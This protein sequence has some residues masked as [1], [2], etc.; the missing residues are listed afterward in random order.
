MLN[1]QNQGEIE[2]L[3]R[4]QDDRD[5]DGDDDEGFPAVLVPR[6]RAIEI[7]ANENV[8]SIEI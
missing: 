6:A 4:Q 3:R 1:H 5:D 7:G 2:K 8:K